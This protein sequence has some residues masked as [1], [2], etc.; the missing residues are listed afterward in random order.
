MRYFFIIAFLFVI[1]LLAD[2]NSDQLQLTNQKLVYLTGIEYQLTISNVD[3][4]DFQKSIAVNCNTDTI[5]SGTISEFLQPDKFLHMSV[6]FE[7]S[8]T[9]SIVV[10]DKIQPTNIRVIPGWLSILPALFAIA[11]A[12]IT[13]QVLIALF[14]GVWLG[15]TFIFGYNP[16]TGFL[17]TLSD[18][19]SNA[20]ADPDRTSI[21]IFTLALG[22]MVGV[23]SK[24]GGTKGIVESISRFASNARRGQIATWLMG[25]IIFFDDYAN[26]LI[27]GNTMR[28]LT[29]KLKI[30]REK[31][32]YLV[33]STAAPVA[34]IAIISTWIGYELSLIDESFTAIKLDQNA[35]ITFFRTIPVNFYPIFALIFGLAVAYFGRDLFSMYKAEQRA[36]DNKGLMRENAV[37]LS[38]MDSDELTAKE[39]AP[40][41]WYNALIPVSLVIITTLAGLWFT[42]LQGTT[43]PESELQS[44]GLI[45]YVSTIIGNSNSFAVL[46]WAAFIGGFAA[47]LLAL[48][49]KIL[50]LNESI[51]AWVAGVKAMIMAAL[52]LTMAWAIGTI[53]TDI[54]TANYVISITENLLSPHWLPTLSFIIAGLIAF[55]TGTSWGTMAILAPLVIPLA[56]QLPAMDTAISSSTATG[57]FLSSIASILAGA[58]FGDHC[59]PISD[60][61]I[62][63]SMASG[64]DHI[65]HVRTQLPYA[66]MVAGLSILFGYLPVG[67]G[68]PG[69]FMLLIGAIIIILFVRF[70]GKKVGKA[71]DKSEN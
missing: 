69:W 7:S 66:L 4:S 41:R 28:P 19:I 65:D 51:M 10:D 53:C 32:S 1:P 31:L 59:S 22:G 12:L 25:V 70:A 11:L 62:M 60:T 9:Y 52:I 64:A 39:D 35:Y 24:S 43:L 71:L 48:F 46:M 42:G 5:I 17:Y 29:D 36:A 50:T 54:Q 38:D 8:G 47:I 26:T 18:Y 2:N 23:I 63:S 68:I 13:R 49:Q 56:Y 33:D 58:T 40:L 55:A 57:I 45:H 6:K 14:A 30:S 34:N 15:A 44:M 3:S 37:P 21:L 27:V 61:T 16:F 20:L 67:Y